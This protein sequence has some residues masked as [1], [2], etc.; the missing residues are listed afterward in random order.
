M[1]PNDET[2]PDTGAV[3]SRAEFQPESGNITWRLHLTSSP[4]RV[5]DTL[6]TDT[7]R[8]RFWAESTEESANDL[9]WHLLNEPHR[10]NGRILERVPGRSI[11]F[12]YFAGT[13]AEFVLE[14]DGSGGTDLTLRAANVDDRMRGEMTA[15]WVTVLM[16]LKAAAEFDI[17]LRNHDPERT[18]DQLFVDD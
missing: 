5:Y 9:V 2:F 10:I 7:G 17:D 15:G 8:A 11:T 4:E 18:W 6:S 3:D 16:S 12:E 14:P 13:T 1:T